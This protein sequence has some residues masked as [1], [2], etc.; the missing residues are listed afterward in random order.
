VE[1]ISSYIDQAMIGGVL[2]GL[3]VGLAILWLLYAQNSLWRLSLEDRAGVALRNVEERFG[4]SRLPSGFGPRVRSRG[5][6]GSWQ[7][8]LVIR[9]GI[10]GDWVKLKARGPGGVIRKSGPLDRVV[11]H[12]DVWLL[13]QLDLLYEE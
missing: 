7:V 10:R 13:D 4:L 8:D 9:G 1:G 12:L 3:L 2:T 11:E 5:A 6:V